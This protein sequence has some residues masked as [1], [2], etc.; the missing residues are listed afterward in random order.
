MH[1]I[2]NFKISLKFEVHLEGLVL[3]LYIYMF[4]YISIFFSIIQEYK[5][6]SKSVPVSVTQNTERSGPEVT[7][8]RKAAFC[9]RHRPE[10]NGEW[11]IGYLE[12]KRIT[13][14]AD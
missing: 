4:K 12:V 6:C 10:E 3:Y 5:S 2:E 1:G 13:N 9:E 7:A 11:E 14:G 8:E